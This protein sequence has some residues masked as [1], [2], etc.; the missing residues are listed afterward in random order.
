MEWNQKYMTVIQPEGIGII[1][2][3]EE[4]STF[5]AHFGQFGNIEIY[6]CLTHEI[7][8]KT[9]GVHIQCFYPDIKGRSLAE[10]KARKYHSCFDNYKYQLKRKYP[11]GRL[12]LLYQSLK[13]YFMQ[14]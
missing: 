8:L 10:L 2:S 11:Q 6:D 3:E 4:F 12:K 13:V 1:I 7:I 9:K 5:I 14:E